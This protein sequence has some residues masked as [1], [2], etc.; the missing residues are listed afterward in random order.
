MLWLDWINDIGDFMLHSGFIHLCFSTVLS[1]SCIK[2]QI[3]NCRHAKNIFFYSTIVKLL[4]CVIR[5]L[6]KHSCP[7][8]S[9]TVCMSVYR[10]VSMVDDLP[11]KISIK[12]RF[13]NNWE[14]SEK[15]AQ[16]QSPQLSRHLSRTKREEGDN[17]KE[18][19]AR[20][21]T[22]LNI[23]CVEVQQ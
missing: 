6:N 3:S 10:R 12:H 19:T 11:H 18:S 2:Y 15:V 1:P 9:V 13:S 17:C 7:K 22:S 21:Q 16:T 14:P 4:V 5:T 23:L 20:A 8:V